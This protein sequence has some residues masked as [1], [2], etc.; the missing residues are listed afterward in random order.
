[1]RKL[2]LISCLVVVMVCCSLLAPVV[3]AATTFAAD[4]DLY[5]TNIKTTS[6]AVRDLTAYVAAERLFARSLKRPTAQLRVLVRSYLTVLDQV[7]SST[8][9]IVRDQRA[10]DRLLADVLALAH[11]KRVE[12][13]WIVL[14]RGA[15]G[16][17]RFL[18]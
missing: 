6:D 7:D 9:R 15:A 4:L 10:S 11:G 16:Q 2:R 8:R 13:A 18:A 1:M 3:D 14:K 12:A 17:E 5:K